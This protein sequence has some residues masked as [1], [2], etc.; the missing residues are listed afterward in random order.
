MDLVCF[1]YEAE[2]QSVRKGRL[3]STRTRGAASNVANQSVRNTQSIRGIM[4]N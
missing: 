2:N 3:R 4:M 1:A